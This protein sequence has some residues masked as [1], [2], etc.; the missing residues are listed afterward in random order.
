MGSP[1][2]LLSAARFHLQVP[3]SQTVFLIQST[4]VARRVRSISVQFN[5]SIS[6]LP[7]MLPQVFPAGAISRGDASFAFA[8]GIV[9]RI[10]WLW[11][12]GQQS[13][14]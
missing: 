14:R 6:G 8:L 4:Q 5:D 9:S 12:N 13:V 1:T 11:R 7:G 2:F 3:P 10:L